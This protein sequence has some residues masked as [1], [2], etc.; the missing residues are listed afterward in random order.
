MSTEYEVHRTEGVTVTLSESS[1]LLSIDL[2]GPEVAAYVEEDSTQTA[3]TG[4][5]LTDEDVVQMIVGM[6]KAASYVSD[7]PESI[8]ARILAALD[9]DPYLGT[10]PKVLPGPPPPRTVLEHA[11]GTRMYVVQREDGMFAVVEAGSPAEAST[12]ETEV[13]HDTLEDAHI[14][15]RRL[16]GAALAPQAKDTSP[17]FRLGRL[18][19]RMK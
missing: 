1:S 2:R 18:F 11:A 15:Y 17:E 7:D 5:T 9:A 16:V 8:K 6:A 12:A 13:W 4:H 19:M 3:Y 14:R 10:M